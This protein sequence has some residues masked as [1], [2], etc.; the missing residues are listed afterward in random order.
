MNTLVRCSFS[1]FFFCMSLDSL[2]RRTF[3]TSPRP[4][5]FDRH[6]APLS[7]WLSEVL[8]VARVA[9]GEPAS[10]RFA[11]GPN[12]TFRLHRTTYY[13]IVVFWNGTAIIGLTCRRLAGLAY[14]CACADRTSPVAGHRACPPRVKP[15]QAGTVAEEAK[16][17]V[18]LAS[19]KRP[20]AEHSEFQSWDDT[21]LGILHI[22]IYTK[23]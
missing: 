23:F 13:T 14:F 17:K 5:Y 21:I 18:G 4:I 3:S 15:R 8:R 1:F 22:F 7:L 20:R 2:V 16:K 6:Q 12:Y 19:R 10:A 9:K 11:T